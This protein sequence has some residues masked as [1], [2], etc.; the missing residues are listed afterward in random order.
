M[1]NELIHQKNA[2]L[3]LINDGQFEQATL[4]L[5]FIEELWEK[6]NYA[7]KTK[8]LR[9][10]IRDGVWSRINDATHHKV[11]AKWQKMWDQLKLGEI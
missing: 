7:Y 8:E 2:L 9:F 5:N 4:I 1:E 11:A 3:N 6:C 10:R